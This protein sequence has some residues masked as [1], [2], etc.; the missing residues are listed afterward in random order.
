MHQRKQQP[1]TRPL[2]DA[3]DRPNDDAVKPVRAYFLSAWAIVAWLCLLYGFVFWRHTW[4]PSPKDA[5]IPLTEFSE[6]RARRF[7]EELQAIEG[8]YRTLGSV[9]NEVATPAWLLRHLEAFQAQCHSPCNMEIEVQK[10][11]GA[12]GLNFLAQFQNI[13]ANVTNV[14]VR[15]SA[16]PE[17]S[18]PSLL[19]SS[20]YDAAIGA[21][22]A[23]DDG[24]NIAIMLELL[25]N[26]VARP[27]TATALVFNFNGA[28]ETFL[29]ASHGFITQHPWR[30]S[31]AAF[32][33]LEA[34]GAGGRELLF[35]TGSDVLAMA[36]AHGAPYPHASTIAQEVFQSG[37]IPGETDYRTYTEYG[38]VPGMDFA[39]VANGYVYHTPLDDI[40][41][42]QL[43]AIQRFGENVQGTIA[44]L[45]ASPATLR[46][47]GAQSSLGGHIFFDVFG[48]RTLTLS[49]EVSTFI[50]AA[51]ALCMLLYVG[52]VS[53]ITWREKLDAV[54]LLVRL[55]LAG[56]G[57]GLLVALV[58]CAYAPM[59]WFASPT[60]RLWV[61]VFPV[62]AGFLHQLPTDDAVALRSLVQPLVEAQSLMWL[63]VMALPM[64]ARGIQSLYLVMAWVMCPLAAQV[65][66][67]SLPTGYSPRVHAGLLLAGIAVP[68]L[69]SV[70]IYIVALQVFIPIMGRA[71]TSLP[72]DLV[73]ALLM[74]LLSLLTL[75]A[76]TPVLCFVRPLHAAHA[77]TSAIALTLL[78]IFVA[79]VS[80]P[81]S[82]ECPKRI[83]VQHIH[84]NFTQRPDAN[85]AGLWVLGFDFQGLDPLRAAFGTTP[86][87]LAM[88]AP[89]H[90]AAIPVVYDNFP[91]V[92]PVAPVMPLKNTWY[93]PTMDA[94]VFAV[95]T[96]LEVV[97]S[98]V[99][100]MTRLR[101]LHLHLSG[102][103]QINMYMDASRTKLASWSLGN[104]TDGVP[105]QIDDVYL[106][107]F[108]TGGLAPASF[109][110]WV[111]VAT[112]GPIDVAYCGHYLNG[113][114]P[115]LATA[116]KLLPDWTAHTTF[117]S[118]WTLTQL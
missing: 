84:R 19:L 114:T 31:V 105:S 91:W 88:H 7:L 33:N 68:L 81:Y 51:L 24:V 53:R 96:L 10:P 22:A 40:S 79:C 56:L 34:A 109:H 117:T 55:S 57:T 78:C 37:V 65:V 3:V 2:A 32:L 41:R 1:P 29:Q 15:L 54:R 86:W 60:T 103:S 25:Q 115:D 66:A 36:Y 112:D 82:T 61:F 50:H 94:P 42:I 106:F 21:A 58:L 98:R 69:H 35:Q 6:E 102:P 111:D 76:L 90:D 104:G 16:S 38:D 30:A 4:L 97:S 45:F 67:Q 71:G 59:S 116:A 107:Q 8:G 110:F 63:L 12:F 28:E 85:D 18:P 74:A 62:A 14:L 26:A 11:E 13:Y 48:Y 72:S 70:Q 99:D 95:P 73:V 49:T 23:S 75:S 9:A 100:P 43:G 5:S 20:H 17:A 87:A 27:P 92:Y 44:Q 113:T 89:V 39:Y 93:L 118:S 101:R 108:S 77:K 52:L 64:F 47:L 83:I 80:N 46:S